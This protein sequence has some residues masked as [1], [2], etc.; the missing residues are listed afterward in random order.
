MWSDKKPLDLE[1]KYVL[2]TKLFLAAGKDGYECLAN[3]DVKPFVDF[4][5]APNLQDIVFQSF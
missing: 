3:P 1:K 5:S 4:D 2:A